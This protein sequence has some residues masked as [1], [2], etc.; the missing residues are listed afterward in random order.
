VDVDREALT[1]SV[2][3]S[4][5]AVA[6]ARNLEATWAPSGA[7]RAVRCD[8]RVTAALRAGVRTATGRDPRAIVS[9]AGHDAAPLSAA[10]PVG[11]LFVRCRGGIS[12]NPDEHVEPADLEA[13]V[14]A[15]VAAV[16]H[17]ARGR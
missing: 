14:D 5:V 8:E 16:E 11:M 13:A 10:M 15:L 12:H 2:H 4:V 17:L 1:R 3:R 9:G 6:R 7:S